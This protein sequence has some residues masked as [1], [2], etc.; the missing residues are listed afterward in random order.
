MT[1]FPLSHVIIP[2]TDKKKFGFPAIKNDHAS[3]ML[4]ILQ[5]FTLSIKFPSYSMMCLIWE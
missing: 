3:L 4:F 1:T 5:F 2:S